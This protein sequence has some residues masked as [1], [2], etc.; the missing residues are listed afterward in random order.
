MLIERGAPSIFS[1][2]LLV[3]AKKKGHQQIWEMWHYT[4]NYAF[5]SPKN[6]KGW[7]GHF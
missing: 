1:V 5:G 7:L 6:L 2:G 4:C 3:K